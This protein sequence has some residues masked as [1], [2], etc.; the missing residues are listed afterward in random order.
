MK[1]TIR[2]FTVITL[3]YFACLN[4]CA[5]YSNKQT[6]SEAI[7]GRWL[8][9]SS[10]GGISGRQNMTPE[11]AGYTRVIQFGRDGVFREFHDG[12]L[13]VS[14]SFTIVKKKTIFGHGRKVICFADTTGQLMDQ[15]IMK[16]TATELCLADPCHDC[17]GHSYVRLE[18]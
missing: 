15:V 3:L 11:T 18:E 7:S 12:R 10:S 4:S 16:L 13:V 9:T 6:T 2:I 5:R 8:W 1:S 17:F 14:N